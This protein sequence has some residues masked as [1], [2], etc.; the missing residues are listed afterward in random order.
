[1][2]IAFYRMQ[3]VKRSEGRN[4]LAA[5]A[6]I[7]C[8]RLR[9]HSTAQIFD[10]RRKGGLHCSFL[11]A[12]DKH[13]IDREVL[14][15][16]AELAETRS[17]S[18]VARSSILAL[19]HELDEGCYAAIVE[20]HA[21]YLSKRHSIAVDVAI[22]L[23]GEEGD[24]R[25]WHAHLLLTTRKVA[26]SPGGEIRCGQKTREL[27]EHKTGSAIINDWRLHWQD[28]VNEAIR[29]LGI[30]ID[31]RS[32]AKQGLERTA[33]EHLGPAK[34]NLL[35]RTIREILAEVRA[36]RLIYLDAVSADGRW[37]RFGL[38]VRQRRAEIAAAIRLASRLTDDHERRDVAQTGK[39]ADSTV[40]GL[41]TLPPREISIEPVHGRAVG[42]ASGL[43]GDHET[44]T[45]P[46]HTA[47]H[48]PNEGGPSRVSEAEH[49]AN[50]SPKA[51]LVQELGA[52]SPTRAELSRTSELE[53]P[54]EM[55]GAAGAG[56]RSETSHDEIRD[57]IQ[58]D[59]A[60][61][62]GSAA[63]VTALIRRLRS[64]SEREALK[65]SNNVR[66]SVGPSKPPATGVAEARSADQ[67]RMQSASVQ[68]VAGGSGGGSKPRSSGPAPTGIPAQ[69]PLAEPTIADLRALK[70]GAPI[71][72]TPSHGAAAPGTPRDETDTAGTKMPATSAPTR[73][74]SSVASAVPRQSPDPVAPPSTPGHARPPEGE[75][76]AP[77]ASQAPARPADPAANPR[78][79]H[80]ADRSSVLSGGRA[81]S[82]G[83]AAVPAE[84]TIA[85]LSARGQG[86]PIRRTPSHSAAT[87]GAPITP[88]PGMP[89]NGA[90]NA[91]ITR[92]AASAPTR[93]PISVALTVSRSSSNPVAPAS[94]IS[95]DRP[96]GREKTAPT[97]SQ[98][99]ARPA[100]PEVKP[101]LSH[102][103]SAAGRGRT[104]PAATQPASKPVAQHTALPG[105]L[106]PSNAAGLGAPASN[107]PAPLA[108]PHPKAP[109]FSAGSLLSV[110]SDK[111]EAA[112]PKPKGSITV[113]P[114][115]AAA[116]KSIITGLVVSAGSVAAA[117]SSQPTSAAA[118]SK[119]ER[120][121]QPQDGPGKG[122]KDAPVASAQTPEQK[123]LSALRHASSPA[124]DSL[125]AVA[126]A[127]HEKA[128][129]TNAATPSRPI[130]NRPAGGTTPAE[131]P[132]AVQSTIEPLD[133]LVTFQG[134]RHHQT[135]M[136]AAT[137]IYASEAGNDALMQSAVRYFAALTGRSKERAN[138]DC[139]RIV[140]WARKGG[141]R[142]KLP[143]PYTSS[144][145]CQCACRNFERNKGGRDR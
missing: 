70:Q 41:A 77:T 38:E 47:S 63:K 26:I 99:P 22:H 55:T 86:G 118:G 54:A 14:W 12:P 15:N 84:P 30:Q 2:A 110:A 29:H 82:S 95:P 58:S 4:A 127:A 66:R 72:R 79:G 123:A 44:E 19:P 135:R 62:E 9:D 64:E 120:A 89:R 68:P 40:Q 42:Q 142:S 140:E 115:P 61:P 80:S 138:S 125:L 43:V 145:A 7:A 96:P 126:K 37:R 28:C 98:A 27:D 93:P 109:G 48:V 45:P 52:L 51:S 76:T 119:P 23:P 49:R 16:A 18:V 92:P 83:R 105:Q 73:S 117:P 60:G 25:N 124:P 103:A 122:Q 121:S 114:L 71:K 133:P 31:V 116:T 46:P 3:T 57:G 50:P 107:A 1:M 97:A 128:T 87:S 6:Y 10:Y 104:A 24:E 94:T 106:A 90:N 69:R 53:P 137:F 141:D 11:V 129:P 78:L 85:D 91:G 75:K 113:P 101:S 132:N 56:E 144:E 81:K 112:Q 35:R 136:L 13:E 100:A 67:S 5:A 20:K 39:P 131:V 34:S 74:P 108:A 143:T 102:S 36:D 134:A 8:Q 33:T 139:A 21:R 88:S 32:Y 130:T 17:N 111:S 65:A 59:A